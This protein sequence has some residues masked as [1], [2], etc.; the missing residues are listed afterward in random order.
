MSDMPNPTASEPTD[1]PQSQTATEFEAVEK[2]IQAALA[3]PFEVRLRQHKGR[4]SVS[5]PELG[6]VVGGKDLAKAHEELLVLRERQIR[7]FAAEGLLHLLTTPGAMSLVV[8]PD[9]G[10]LSKLKS[11]L[12]KCLIVSLLFLSG[13]NLL[14]QRLSDVG[15]VLEKKLQGLSNWTPAQVEWH[16]ERSQ[17]I[18]QKLG[19]TIRELLVMF[20]TSGE[21]PARA[22]ANATQ[23]NA[24]QDNATKP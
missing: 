9:Q 15:Y 14:G 22:D 17:L 4:Y 6:L 20:R 12:V 16:R 1:A 10:T 21:L 18:A 5:I 7:E 24:T 2:A 11:F 3:A 13:V 8:Q 23:G 19:P